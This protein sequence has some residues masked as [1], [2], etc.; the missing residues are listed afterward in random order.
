[1]SQIKLLHSGGNGVIIAAPDS[2]PV[3]DRTL[4][5]PSD[6]DGTILTTNSSVG[7]ILQ[8]LQD[9]KTDTAT[10]NSTSF[11]AISG[12]SQ[13]ITTTGSN[14]VLIRVYLHFGLVGGNP[15]HFKLVRTTGGSD[16]DVFLGD[17]DGNRTRATMGGL[18]ASDTWNVNHES[19]EFLESPSAGTHTYSI[20]W[21]IISGYN[22]AYLNRS[23]RDDNYNYASRTPSV[24]TLMEVAA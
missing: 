9:T 16:T 7:K 10:T 8:V 24:I 23:A 4:K 1:M 21:K 20:H 18:S 11:S 2:N 13:A 17:A 12:L 15:V 3:S 14:K 19:I 5:L 6:G 22:A